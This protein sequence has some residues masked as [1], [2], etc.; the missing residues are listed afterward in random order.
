MILRM[1]ERSMNAWPS[2]QTLLYDGWVIRFSGG[3]TKR[4]NS[5]CP[6]YS[7]GLDV[8]EK[9]NYCEKLYTSNQLP[10]VYKLTKA[11]NPADLDLILEKRGYRRID[12]TAVRIA[13]I[14]E[15]NCYT[16]QFEV[17]AEYDFT[18]EWVSTLITCTSMSNAD[19]IDVMKKMLSNITGDR[20]CVR[21]NL[22]DE[23][24]ACGFGVIEDGYMGI[25]DIV[26]NPS[27]RGRGY[28]R[29]IM[30]ELL[31]EARKKNID[32]AY[33][34]VVVGNTIAERLYDSLGF[35]EIYRYWYRVKQ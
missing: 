31:R 11:C 12:E 35:K 34:S 9:I 8:E 23:P 22:A 20:V 14:D 21:I 30:Q 1:E 2:L 19:K 17:K 33:L 28:G 18:R 29:A 26:V 6:I 24:V 5:I 3:Y 32:K 4:A 15:E 13:Q 16:N 27:Y 25:Y 10:V 7:S